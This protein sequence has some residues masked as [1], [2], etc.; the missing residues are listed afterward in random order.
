MCDVFLFRDLGVFELAVRGDVNG[1]EAEVITLVVRHLPIG[2]E[3]VVDLSEIDDLDEVAATAIVESIALRRPDLV[4][5][6]FVVGHPSVGA[7]LEAAGVAEVSC[8]V[9]PSA[10]AAREALARR[11]DVAVARL[12]A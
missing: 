12:S 9:A 4:S 2:S 7:L 6:A 8:G 3:I 1:S 10:T 11:H 5:A